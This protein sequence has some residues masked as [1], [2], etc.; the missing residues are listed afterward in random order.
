MDLFLLNLFYLTKMK[1]NRFC[2]NI[3]SQGLSLNTI[4]IAAIVLVVLIVL[5]YIFT[6]R[7]GK[8]TTELTEQE[9]R[10]QMSAKRTSQEVFNKPCLNKIIAKDCREI[11]KETECKKLTCDYDSKKEPKCQGIPDC[12][13]LS[14]SECSSYG[15]LCETVT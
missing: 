10:A 6:G 15:S 9:V 3:K 11:T 2:K 14:K 1:K 8:S 12:G 5:W 13:V 7:L 4:I